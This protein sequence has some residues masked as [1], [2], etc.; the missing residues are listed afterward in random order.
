MAESEEELKIYDRKWGILLQVS[1][2]SEVY[3]RVSKTIK[4]SPV[5]CELDN[6]SSRL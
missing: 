2:G 5:L 1:V 6:D 3:L 4:I